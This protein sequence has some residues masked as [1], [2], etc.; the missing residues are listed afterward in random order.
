MEECAILHNSQ[1]HGL[2]FSRGSSQCFIWIT[3]QLHFSHKSCIIKLYLFFVSV[4]VASFEFVCEWQM[5]T[6]D[7]CSLWK[8]QHVLRDH[9]ALKPPASMQIYCKTTF[10]YVNANWCWTQNMSKY[11]WAPEFMRWSYLGTI[12]L[13][14]VVLGGRKYKHNSTE[15]LPACSSG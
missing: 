15:I 2:F 1:I 5:E 6:T 10:R 12:W 14:T 9:Q 4:A 13:V 8:A 7:L 11:L 3:Q